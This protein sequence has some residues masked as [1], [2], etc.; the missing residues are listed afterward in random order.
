M[1]IFA[2]KHF[3]GKQAKLF[4]FLINLAIYLRA[5]LALTVRFIKHVFL[6]LIDFGYIVV[7][8]YALTNYWKMSSIEFPQELIRYSIP[9]YATTWLA[10]TF[11]NGGYDAPIKLFKFLKGVFAGTLLILIAYAIL[12]KSWQF[13]RLFIFVGAGWVLSYYLISRIFLHLV[14]R[15]QFNL[16]ADRGT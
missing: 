12:P 10:A 1:I 6:P 2:Q 5:F 9:I 11:F 13:S 7:G 14:A 16:R 15:K 3:S 8:L 4:S